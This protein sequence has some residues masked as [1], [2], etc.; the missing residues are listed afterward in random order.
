VVAWGGKGYAGA[1]ENRKI[2]ISREAT[3]ALLALPIGID[4]E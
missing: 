1:R 3:L 4:S 2:P